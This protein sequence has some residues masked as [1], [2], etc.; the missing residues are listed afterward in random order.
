MA[1]PPQVEVVEVAYGAFP[2]AS[3]LNRKIS[4]DSLLLRATLDIRWQDPD[5]AAALGRAEGRLLAL[6]PTFRRHQCRGPLAYHVFTDRRRGTTAASPSTM[7]STSDAP[8][9]DAC[10]ALAHLIEHAIID[11]EC[12]IIDA[13]RCSGVTGARR[14]PPGRFDIMVECPDRL[15]GSLCLSLAIAAL[16]A[17]TN[18]HAPGLSEKDLL[19]V[20][21]LAWQRRGRALT[22]AGV[23]AA[24]G[25]PM[26]AAA[27]AMASLRD[28]GYLT[29][30]AYSVNISGIPEYTMTGGGGVPTSSS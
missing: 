1:S 3:A 2:I 18:G 8:P 12:G 13:A 5:P 9:F 24:F 28:L 26:A 21:R 4:A 25:W 7:A 20:A 16:R 14:Q 30:R 19:A 29:E 23:A 6:S 27:R 15:V 10:L 22:P 11:F 17:A